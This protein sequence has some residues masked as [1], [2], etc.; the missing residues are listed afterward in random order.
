MNCT[1]TLDQ[2]KKLFKK[3]YSDLNNHPIDQPFDF[4]SYAIDFYNSILGRTQDN[5]LALSYVSLLPQNIRVNIGVDKDLSKKLGGVFQEIVA[6]ES[7]FDNLD[8]VAK[9]VTPDVNVVENIKNTEKA[10]QE[11]SLNANKQ[12]TVVEPIA[13]EE[14]EYEAVV[15]SFLSDNPFERTIEDANSELF[16]S[17][18]KRK[19]I[20]S[21][22]SNYQGEPSTI[23]GIGR[24]RLKV[25]SSSQIAEQHLRSDLQEKLKA[26]DERVIKAHK[27]GV[28]LVVTDDFG[29]IIYFDDKFDRVGPEV[30][31][32]AYY[33]IRNPRVDEKG[34]VVFDQPYDS[35]ETSDINRAKALAKKNNIS[36][37]NAKAIVTRQLELY[38]KIREYI[39]KAPETNNITMNI[40]GGAY[41]SVITNKKLST[42][43]SGLNLTDQV[44][45]PYIATEDNSSI[46]QRKGMTYTKVQGIDN[47][48]QIEKGTFTKELADKLASLLID[49]IKIET[50]KGKRGITAGER[51]KLFEQFVYTGADKIRVF[52]TADDTGI[53]I[54]I[55]GN[56]LNTSDKDKAK[57]QLVSY[58]T[59][60]LPTREVKASQIKGK[61]II[62][63]TDPEYK[64]KFGIDTILES[65]DEGTGQSRFYVIE[66]AKLNTKKDLLQSDKYDDFNIVD[67]VLSKT[68]KS[69][70]EFIKN[71]FVLF[72]PL[73][74][75]GHIQSLNPYLTFEPKEGEL[76]KLS[77]PIAK[78]IVEKSKTEV[79][80]ESGINNN[81]P[82]SDVSPLDKLRNKMRNN[83]K[84]NK[85]IEQQG[86]E[87]TE[88]QIKA[89]LKWYEG[90][91]MS[92]FF[93]FE[94]AFTMVNKTQPNSIAT[95]QMN[96][97]TLYKGA[98]YS[99]L[100]H[101]SWH[102]FTQAFLNKEQKTSL[103][104]EARKKTG[105]FKDYKGN[106]V[107][108]AK[109]N[110]LQIEEY[111]AEEFRSYALSGG[112]SIKDAPVRN[113]IFKRIWN[114]LKSLFGD[115]TISQV[116]IEAKANKII[117]DLFD[118]LYIGDLSEYTFAAENRNFH[119][120]NKGLEKIK[121][122]EPLDSLS[123]ED[124]N[125]LVDTL[126]SLFSEFADDINGG[127]DENQRLRK[128][129]LEAK[130]DLSSEEK[131]ELKDL[132][133]Q[134]T[135]KFSTVL[136]STKD[137]L[138]GAYE[139]AQLRLADIHNN[140]VAELNKPNVDKGA[141]QKKLDLLSYA[142]RN[143][144]NIESLG[145]NE[146]GKGVIGY[147]LYKSEFISPESL[148]DVFEVEQDQL[149]E[150]QGKE[151]YDRGGNEQS[152][153]DL[154]SKEIIYMIRGLHKTDE[155]GKIET[156]KLGI[157]ELAS[158]KESYRRLAE[159]LKGVVTPQEMRKL[160]EKE[161]NSYHPLKQLLNKLG[162]V[163]YPG[164]SDREVDN[165]TKFWQTFNKPRIELIQMNIDMI[166]VDETGK[167]LNKPDFNVTI[168]NASADFRKVGQA[169]ESA[170]GESYENPYMLNDA[171][172]NYLNL[173][174]ITDK[175]PNAESIRGKE[176][177]FL[178]DIGITL[179]KSNAV[180]DALKR[181]INDGEINIGAFPEKLKGLLLSGTKVRNINTIINKVEYVDVDTDKTKILEGEW[182]NY[183]KLQK[184]EM[185]Y[186]DMH[187]DFMVTNAAGDA[188]SEFSLN[189]TLTQMLKRINDS[190]SFV[191]LTAIPSMSYLN[192]ERNPFSKASVWLNSL[193]D[194]N[195]PGG[196]KKEGAVIN[197]QNLSGVAMLQNGN[198]L[199]EGVVSASADEHTKLI[200]D[201]HLQVLNGTPE[202]IRSADKKTSLSVFLND[203]NTEGKNKRLYVDTANF[204]D[205]NG[206][207]IGEDQAFAIVMPYI[208]AELDRVNECRKALKPNSGVTQFDFDYL[209]RGKDFVMFDDVLSDEVKKDLYEV[210]GEIPEQL[211]S[212]I[213]ADVYKYFNVKF[214]ETNDMFNEAKFIANGL[215]E[216]VKKDA[217]K[218]NIAKK[219][220]DDDTNVDNA[221][222][223]SWVY[224][225]W[226]HHFEEMI[227][228]YGD[229]ALYNTNK[230]DLHK[231]NASINS[232]GDILRTDGDFIDHVNNNI[233]KP[234]TK[235]KNY[236][237]TPYKGTFNSAVLADIE[238]GSAYLEEYEKLL[239]PQAKKYGKG[240]VNE[241]D[242]QG[243]IGFD[244][245]R[246]IGKSLSDWT[247]EQEELYQ[248]IV[249]GQMFEHLDLNTL[250][251]VRKMSY[252]GSLEADGLPL[253]A[254]H[255]FSLF[256]LIPT[257]IRGT[258]LEKLHDKMMR[259]GVD[260]A[261]FKSGSKVATITD[262][263]K[264]DKLY[265][266]NKLRTFDETPFTKNTVY[267]DYLKDQIKVSTKF[268]NKVTFFSQLRK[269]VDTGLMENGKPT[270]E[271]NGKLRDN[272]LKNVFKL[273][274]VKKQ[275]LLREMGWK[276]DAQGKPTGSLKKLLEVVVRELDRSDL[277]EHERAF[278]ELG[279]DGKLKHDLSLSQSADKI[280]RV[281]M[282]IVNKRLVRYKV[283][284]EQLV[285]VSSA[286]FEN[287]GYAYTSERK[288]DAP[289]AEDLDKYGSNDLPTYHRGPDGLT[290]AAKVKI[291]LQGDF[292][293]LLQLEDVKS[294]VNEMN[295]SQINALNTLIKDE[296]WLNKDDNRKMITMI[297][298][299]IPTQ[300][301]NSMEFME[302]YEFLP[303]EAGNIIIS[304]PEITSKS[305]TDFD[306]DKL[307]M[308]MPNITFVNGQVTLAKEYSKKE[309]KLIYDTLI[310]YQVNKATLEGVDR[311]Q[312]MSFMTPGKFYKFEEA[313]IKLLGDSYMEDLKAIVKEDNKIPEFDEFYEKLNGVK[314]V[315]NNII[316]SVREILEQPENFENLIRPND[317]NLVEPLA[318]Q[319][320]SDVS[321][322]NSKKVVF[323]DPRKSGTR[324]L[325]I[326]FNLYKH[327]SNNIGKETLGIGAVDNT[328]NSIF[329]AIGF[330]MNPSNS[331][332]NAEY[333]D[334]KKIAKPSKEEAS[335]LNKYR[336]QVMLLPHNK[337]KDENDESVISLGKLKDAAGEN[338]ISDV[339]SQLINGWVDVAKDAWIF[340]IQGNKEIA[341]TLLFMVQAGVPF[342]TAVYLVSQPLI[343]EYVSQQRLKK[344]TFAEAL[345][346]SPSN[347][348]RFRV[349]ARNAILDNPKYGFEVGETKEKNIYDATVALTDKVGAKAFDDKVLL[350]NIKEFKGTDEERA[351][352]LHFL[353][354]ENMAKVITAVKSK[355]NVDT[356]PSI[357]LFE[358]QETM[359]NIQAL[360]EEGRIP[361]KFITA[362]LTD[363]TVGAYYTQPFVFDLFKDLFVLR[364]HPVLNNFIA[365]MPFG[366]EAKRAYDDKEKFVSEFRNDLMSYIFQNSACAFDVDT[367]SYKGSKVN[368]TPVKEVKDLKFGAFVKEGVLYVDKNQLK[369]DFEQINYV[370][371]YENRG[372][373]TL[374]QNTFSLQ[375]EYDHFVYE[376]ETLRDAYPFADMQQDV[377]YKDILTKNLKNAKYKK[378][379]ESQED[380]EKRMKRRSYEEWL[381]DKA[382]DNIL[383][384][385]KMF[386][387]HNSFADKFVRIRK[388][389]PDLLDDYSLFRNIQFKGNRMGYRNLKLSNNKL[390][391]DTV[392][393][394]NE[395]LKNLSN[396]SVIKVENVQDNLYISD[397]FSK[398]PLYAFMQSGMNAKSVFSLNRIVP[399]DT[400]IRMMEQPAKEWENKMSFDI[401]TDY[402]NRF[403]ENNINKGTRTRTKNYLSNSTLNNP[404]KAEDIRI[405]APP[406]NQL[407]LFEEPPVIEEAQPQPVIETPAPISDEEV[408]TMLANCFNK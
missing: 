75:S 351:A 130:S 399:Q 205:Q 376:R 240:Q 239:G 241:A 218:N 43:L 188:Q 24:V 193:F 238:I 211:K 203:I 214:Q 21:L 61:R 137:G 322:Y 7:D 3:V 352:F 185:R 252:F 9:F 164:Q 347:P 165:W 44:F 320:E 264:L 279:A 312:M 47:V 249:K 169:W 32:P 82:E 138:T 145:A 358:A 391:R 8:N 340:N 109:A 172:G 343:R 242:A 267:A 276:L 377:D 120:L 230:D 263:G 197:V 160:I 38:K 200:L 325:E 285:Q 141:I 338:N 360:K 49:D 356:S 270:S 348:M 181:A 313:I 33:N 275:E 53:N 66:Y 333:E 70:S 298:A 163:S 167:K 401:L 305:G 389:Y 355:T 291:A 250:F 290:R 341:P 94:E 85:L 324:G 362:I 306:Y 384:P 23:S 182:G 180:K 260:Y 294:K 243:M 278:V 151:V 136:F 315:E 39:N 158:F 37:D 57:S 349:E 196:P 46:G 77:V 319:L 126:D 48:V 209:N 225:N 300:G 326:G 303:E 108:F 118:K 177:E 195:S 89:A 194:L 406:I 88:N 104:N 268:K 261:L 373:A 318:K 125:L 202:L 407:D 345:G 336:R 387:S 100:Y 212:A 27:E 171:A 153:Y 235:S 114:F 259:E 316:Q 183:Q 124:S 68:P 91:P 321:T 34:N 385:W 26:G 97:I 288:F 60:L 72:H 272:F 208:Q 234:L 394:Y 25:I 332:S 71:N 152:H 395:N 342:K 311:N 112:K 96:G 62:K 369:T 293:K 168:G 184:L 254:L 4:K 11:D 292:K 129:E 380:F 80:K 14:P 140:T 331:V 63:T 133:G 223:R 139:Y 363:T 310:Q 93:P 30:G 128:S 314:S 52:P 327:Q 335:I 115:N 144:G 354:I 296:A 299:R 317:T 79:P 150:E 107:S 323:G 301:L 284:G 187:S 50:P 295:L 213:A 344:S 255:K 233:G 161:S 201:L 106:R 74:A 29:G 282:A 224:N 226:I 189:T 13:I 67:G 59:R 113:N 400:F 176:F 220:Y 339:I 110:D 76:K 121:A 155:S 308:M 304:P 383:N 265:T 346:T 116:G 17:T 15:T 175:Y 359:Q 132:Q 119:I 186:S 10:L 237:V 101:E 289:T 221:I 54:V 95:W 251:P 51:I 257:V 283:N 207:I 368:S 258:N 87:A 277:A 381:R 12:N 403:I 370:Q 266:D 84:F 309:A 65:V 337:V 154:A 216:S 217:Q 173:V 227:V 222:I 210:E 166:T 388:N 16:Y 35:F 302:V 247:N 273:G 18:I 103:Y 361:S 231:R 191:E 378:E 405:E 22:Q 229:Y 287:L 256:P 269:L 148:E 142:L 330:Y 90:H 2:Q 219:Y 146:K 353:E 248:R 45:A 274:L 117:K 206:V 198:A 40:N 375:K 236:T 286:G 372:L 73:D 366:K 157:P 86:V 192:R 396:P 392:E 36:L 393:L 58:L 371:E 159:T 379:E 143:F 328:Y 271:K 232:T 5:G 364:N 179:K 245:Y 170:F 123:Y 19:I 397:F 42:P 244:A 111:L 20:S 55:T 190:G 28:V 98:N 131:N 83:S 99:D 281:L 307:P 386:K 102:G 127:L 69:Y 174:K 357:T 147:H 246:I 408:R 199:Q 156:N 228:L 31:K 402:Y 178:N 404:L 56:R 365:T 149:A 367:T 6:Q 398:F 1:L 390:D 81:S 334:L 105:W 280:E 204:I 134:Q 215:R 253:T 64:N 374:N 122:D 78:E 41:G 92:K 329:N 135:F 297:G 262:N 350:K 162:P 382:L